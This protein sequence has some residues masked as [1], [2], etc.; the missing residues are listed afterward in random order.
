MLIGNCTYSVRDYITDGRIDVLN[1]AQQMADLGIKGLEYNDNY[2]E[3]WDEDY[4]DEVMNSATQ[5]GGVMTQLTCG[6][7]FCADDPDEREANVESIASRLRAAAYMGFPTIRANLGRMEAE[8]LNGT[9]GV[10]RS[11]EGLK[12][13]LPVMQE[14]GVKLN[15]ENHGGPS[16]W[17][18]W[19]LK[20]VLLT[21]PAWVGTCP[22]FGNFPLNCRYRELGKVFPYAYHVHAKTH[23]FDDAGEDVDKDYAR[24]IRMLKDVDYDAC[25]CIE[26]EGPGDQIEGV[27]K[28]KALIE[29][30]L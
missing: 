7:N 20:I 2:F 23:V 27:K 25:L 5:V 13:L 18:D 26:F 12:R 14:T 28:T 1:F 19:I 30:Y 9:V 3:S 6:G 22:D 24:I 8:E 21:D 11:I 15:I 4:L 17:G 29:K 10:E 16:L